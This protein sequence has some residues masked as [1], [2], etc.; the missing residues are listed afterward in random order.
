MLVCIRF[1]NSLLAFWQELQTGK[2]CVPGLLLCKRAYGRQDV[3]PGRSNLLALR[4]AESQHSC[5]RAAQAH[6]P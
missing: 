2:A 6:R 5:T 4:L 3:W 1:R